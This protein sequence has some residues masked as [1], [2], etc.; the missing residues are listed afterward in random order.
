MSALSVRVP[1][2]VPE[3]RLHQVPQERPVRLLLFLTACASKPELPTPDWAA[4]PTNVT[5]LLGGE[6][7]RSA[8][9]PLPK[10][11]DRGDSV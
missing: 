3:D 8:Q 7:D 9:R 6:G 1:Q 10:V 11:G 4:V 5:D 2:E